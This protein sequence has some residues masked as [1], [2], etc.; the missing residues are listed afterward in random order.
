MLTKDLAEFAPGLAG[1]LYAPRDCL[2]L[3]V[4]GPQIE[5]EPQMSVVTEVPGPVTGMR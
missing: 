3:H 4:V 2:R 1:F 5:G